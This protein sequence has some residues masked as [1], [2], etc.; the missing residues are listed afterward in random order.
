MLNAPRISIDIYSLFT[1]GF[2]SITTISNFLGNFRN[3]CCV[4]II[5]LIWDAK[6]SP[7]RARNKVIEI[8]TCFI[9]SKLK[10]KLIDTW[11]E[12][13]FLNLLPD[14]YLSLYIIVSSM[15]KTVRYCSFQFPLCLVIHILSQKI[16]QGCLL[17]FRLTS[18]LGI[19]KCC[20]LFLEIV[21]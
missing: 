4:F 13:R 1:I 5:I 20:H 7:N 15:Q 19:E 10:K 14:K 16:L 9:C 6:F 2:T 12:N 21:I 8:N 18:A 3:F 11:Y 17:N